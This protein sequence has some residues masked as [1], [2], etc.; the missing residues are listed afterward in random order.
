LEG[1]RQEQTIGTSWTIWRRFLGTICKQGQTLNGNPNENNNGEDEDED[2]DKFSI[3]TK[4]TK[5]WSGIPYIGSVTENTG[6]Y[7]KIRY[8]DNDEEELNH[9]EVEKYRKKNRGEGRMIS[10]IGQRMQIRKRLGDWNKTAASSERIWQFYF[11]SIK[12]NYT[13]VT[14]KNGTE[15]SKVNTTAILELN[16]IHTSTHPQKTPNQCLMMQYQQT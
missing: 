10:E 9:T 6:K 13:E 15:K 11:R 16:T 12:K 5:N 7:Y 14:E 4:I 8:E 2:K 1:I 3:G